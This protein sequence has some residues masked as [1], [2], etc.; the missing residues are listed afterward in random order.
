[1]LDS[2]FQKLPSPEPTVTIGDLLRSLDRLEAVQSLEL[3]RLRL[4]I[5][6]AKNDCGRTGDNMRM[7]DLVVVARRAA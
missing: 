4:S 7:P 5:D 6:R 1:M 3:Q 2:T